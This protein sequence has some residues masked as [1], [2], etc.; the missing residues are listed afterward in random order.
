MPGGVR[1]ST[2]AMKTLPVLLLCGS[3]L[4][5][6]PFLAREG[7]FP[8]EPNS[9]PAL[10]ARNPTAFVANL[11]QWNHEAR[12]AAR[13]AGNSLLVDERG[14]WAVLQGA[15]GKSS[16]A[17]R[18]SFCAAQPARLS[19][20]ERLAGV[21]HYFH[22]NDRSRWRTDVP[23]YA[24]VR[25]AGIHPGVDVRA[26]E[27]EGHFEYDLLLA[28]DADLARVT[29]RV[30]GARALRIEG[31]GALVLDTAAGTLRQTRPATFTRDA[32]G[33]RQRVECRYVLQGADRFGFAVEGWDRRSELCIDPGLVY[34]TFL[35]GGG[36]EDAYGIAVDAAGIVTVAGSTDSF[37]FPTTPGAFDPSS[38]SYSDVF[39][40]RFDPA[41]APA[42]QLLASTFLGG[43]ALDEARAVAVDAAG[44]ATIVGY[45][46][47]LD[48]PTTANAYSMANQ[49]GSDGVVA[50]IDPRLTG[51]QQL[52]YSTYFGGTNTDDA[53]C[54]A[55][56]TGGIVTFAGTTY[57]TNLP[58]KNAYDTTPN[59]SSD[60]FVARLDPTL[61][62]A[63]QLLYATYLGGS[64]L[65]QALSIAVDAAG[66][67]TFGGYTNSTNYPLVLAFDSLSAGASEGIVSRLDPRLVGSQQLQFSSYVG[68]ASFDGVNTLAVDAAG[69][70]TVGGGTGSSDF[71]TTP[72][73][74]K[75]TVTGLSEGF[76]MRIDPSSAQP[77]LF[78]T[79]LGGAGGSNEVSALA[80]ASDG[81]VTVT[82]T[83]SSPSFPATPGAWNTVFH[84]NFDG[85]LTRLDPR[86][87]AAQQL[88]YSTCVGSASFSDRPWAIAIDA[89]GVAT[90]A[91]STTSF[92][93]PTTPNAWSTTHLGGTY[94]AFVTRVDMLPTGVRRF[95]ASSPGCRGPLSIGVTTM[96]RVGNADFKLT[97]TGAS[98]AA[99]G[100][101]VLG[102]NA[103]QTPV[104]VLGVDVW[105][106]LASTTVLVAT[107]TDSYGGAIVPMPIP[108]QPMLA[109]ARPIAQFVFGGASSPPPCPPLGLAASEALEFTIQP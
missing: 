41:R 78:S 75:R 109:G 10:L 77:V 49:G 44:V 89:A 37:D 12:F 47:S 55:L 73:A 59:G 71:V 30:E 105:V 15:P 83:T 22:G 57:S 31:D 64:Q 14:W 36:R 54:L 68:G 4:L 92:D 8:A 58:L 39:V 17:L 9:A 1:H 90:V 45:S 3:A 63:Q 51:T 38:N 82:G 103:L 97:C 66:V 20:E 19:G 87:S 96:P 86:L 70:V 6:I 62:P 101:L 35:G 52:V 5:A 81:T 18:M 56:G 84:T 32:S 67:I 99:A 13:F 60:V 100:V 61:P 23:R 93:F 7:E 79:F 88:V 2:D 33:V 106:D 85:F 29:M 48:F 43:T 40:T 26:Y 108:N 11:G 95:G 24:S 50:R 53:K 72:N 16:A 104:V 80:L 65:D 28:P 76:V 91:G 21:H 27:S 94:D 102:V 74:F 42:Q 107:S 98:P 34:S 69:I 25:M 46:T